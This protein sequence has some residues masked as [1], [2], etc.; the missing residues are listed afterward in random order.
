MVEVGPEADWSHKSGE[1][2][3]LRLAILIRDKGERQD[4]LRGIVAAVEAATGDVGPDLAGW[5]LVNLA[6]LRGSMLR[7]TSAA[8]TAAIEYRARLLKI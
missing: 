6:F 2:R 7:G 1:G 8:W 5:R 4:R 3:E